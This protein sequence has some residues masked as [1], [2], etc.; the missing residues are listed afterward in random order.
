MFGAPLVVAHRAMTPGAVPNA[1]PS[2]GLAAT[3]GADLVELDVRLSLDRQPV[4]VHDALL[5]P[6]TTGRGW[7]RLWPA[8][9][10]R[11]V[12]S[13]EDRTV[14]VAPLD[15]A[16]KAVPAGG[17]L[18]LHLKDHA[19][20]GP[21]LTRIERAGLEGRTWLWLERPV[22]VRRAIRRLPSLRVTLLRP[23]GWHE[24]VRE[25]YFAEAQWVGAQGVSLPAGEITAAMVAAAHRHHLRVFTRIDSP[26]MAPQ[27]AAIG[28]DGFITNDPGAT[29]LLLA[30]TTANTGPDART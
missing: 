8:R 20:L 30:L 25:R 29:K 19:A 10:L 24:T 1:V 3:A 21:V 15:D 14:G 22:D 17:Q 26:A 4:L 12:H 28:V 7:I 18:A 9:A 6:S 23:N 13:R 5:R 16:L 11:C 27:L 2:I